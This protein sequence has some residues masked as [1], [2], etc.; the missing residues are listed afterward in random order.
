MVSERELFFPPTSHLKNVT[1]EREGPLGGGLVCCSDFPLSNKEPVAH[2]P[3]VLPTNILDWSALLR[4][5]SAGP[6]S[7]QAPPF[8]IDGR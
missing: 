4:T 5:A 6:Q 3:G 8:I 7:S 2:L 1:R